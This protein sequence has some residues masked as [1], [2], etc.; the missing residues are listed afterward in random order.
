MLTINNSSAALTDL[1]GESVSAGGDINND[2]GQDFAVGAPGLNQTFVVNGSA[3]LGAGNMTVTTAA[4]PAGSS[5]IS[6]P[7]G[8]GAFGNSVSLKADIDNDGF[9]DLVVGSPGTLATDNGETYIQFGA[10]LLPSVINLTTSAPKI[11]G[12]EAG[13]T[14]GFSVASGDVNK[15]GH[16]DVIVGAPDRNNPTGGKVYV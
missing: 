4:L 15:D 6:G 2:G 9:D 3:A 14:A 13:S 5:T 16:A 10:A 12:F 1:F 11:I 7:T 8:S